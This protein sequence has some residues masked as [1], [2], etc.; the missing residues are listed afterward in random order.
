MIS[1]N[2]THDGLKIE[3]GDVSIQ[4]DLE[5]RWC[6]FRRAHDYYRRGVDGEVVRYQER[7]VTLCAKQMELLYDEIRNA[8]EHLL[9][10]TQRPERWRFSGDWDHLRAILNLS[11]S[12]DTEYYR[13]QGEMFRQ[14]YFE[15]PPILP[16]DRYRDLVVLP[17]VGCPNRHCNFCAFYRDKPFKAL[18][19]SALAQH[20][21]GLR[22]LFGKAIVARNG[23]FLGSANAMALSQRRL[24][25]ALGTIESQLGVPRRG[26]ASFYDPYFSP[27]RHLQDWCALQ[28]RGLYRLVVGL[29]S[30]FPTL[31]KQLG[32]SSDLTPMRNDLQAI[33]QSGIHLGISVLV[34]A[35]YEALASK[36]LTDT[37]AFLGQLPLDDNDYIY[38][39]PLELE[40]DPPS[41]SLINRQ[42]DE[43]NARIEE[44]LDAKAVRY[45]IGRYRYYS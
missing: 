6:S 45:Q 37:M 33:K 27:H 42:L 32:K 8:V 19:A 12:R 7:A 5:A 36:H 35:G 38:L 16:P 25:T 29:E 20:I 18:D 13:H 14:V 15:Y 22:R 21:G 9:I 17:A 31:R 28:Q 3:C 43:F 40:H 30:G 4:F 10:L 11:F 26:I 34:G 23:I 24:L 44:L 2:I 1:A 39:S 41:P